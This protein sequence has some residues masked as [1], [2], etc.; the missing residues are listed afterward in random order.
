MTCLLVILSK[1]PAK[2]RKILM[3]EHSSDEWNLDALLKAIKQEV[4][5]LELETQTNHLHATASFH[6]S[7]INNNGRTR[8]PEPHKK[9]PCVF[10]KGPHA[11]MDC[12]AVTVPE[13]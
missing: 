13:Q 3:R 9:H 5:I 2:T 10:C 7:A 4:R 8:Q 11:L 6:T 1:P 12:N